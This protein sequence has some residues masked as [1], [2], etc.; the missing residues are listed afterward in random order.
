VLVIKKSA[1][2]LLLM[3]FAVSACSKG[4]EKAPSPAASPAATPAPGASAPAAASPAPAGQ[5]VPA[6][7]AVKPVPAQIPD[8]VARVNGEDVKK[9]ELEMAIKSLEDRARSAVPPEQR[10]AVYR[11]VLDRLI[12]FHLLVQESK[13]RKVLAPPWEVDGQ[14]E[15]IKKQFPSEDAFKQMLQSRG[16]TLEQLRSD[17]AQT[18]S[19]NLMLKSELEQ[20]IAVTEGDSKK[21]FDENK[22]RF[23]Q[24]ESVHA[25]HILIRT[26]ENADAATKAKARAQ[27]DDLLAQLKKGGNFA[28]LAK[29]Y[30][31]DPGSAPNGGDLGFFSKGQMV[32]AFDQAAFS[33]KPGQTSGVVE[34]SF[35]YHIIR[36]SEAKAGRDLGYEEVKGQI[37]DYLKQQLREKK[38]QEFVDQ[39]KA[40][41][42][43]QIYI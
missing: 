23:R 30:S 36:V 6:A 13:A 31:Q 25:S 40:K 22:A 10:D 16:V 9:T 27:A 26:P 39:L 20:K 42:K 12:G 35:G 7:P 43:I 2:L 11:Q 1:V 3:V 17:T 19:V 4:A 37:D 15:Q 29:K 33:L 14:V 38:S 8:V 18:I 32:P 21:F 5:A 24:E 34:T 28:D 41:G